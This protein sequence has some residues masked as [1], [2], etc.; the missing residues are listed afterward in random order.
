MRF[1]VPWKMSFDS[2]H[3]HHPYARRYETI[4]I[5]YDV[6]KNVNAVFFTTVSF[7]SLVVYHRTKKHLNL[8][9][10]TRDR[11][12]QITRINMRRRLKDIEMTWKWP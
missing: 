12:V 1:V 2:T 5:Y 10:Y 7:R 8:C 9:I 11:V 3:N 4:N 6:F